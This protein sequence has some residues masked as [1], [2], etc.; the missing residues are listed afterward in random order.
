MWWASPTARTKRSSP[1]V[2]LSGAEGYEFTAAIL[3]W[4]AEQ[5]ATGRDR[6]VGALGP[7]EAFGIDGLEAGCEEAGVRRV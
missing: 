3:A 7:V 2:H 1:T 5:L 4:G 6:R